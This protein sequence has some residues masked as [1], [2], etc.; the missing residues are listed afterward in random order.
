[1]AVHMHRP[2]R[3]GRSG[4]L[5]TPRVDD[6]RHD[7]R[8]AEFDPDLFFSTGSG[9]AA[10]NQ[11]EQAKAICFTC[12]VQRECLNYALAEGLDYGVFGGTSPD[13]RRKF[14]KAP[15]AQG[16]EPGQRRCED[17]N[18]WFTPAASGRHIYCPTCSARKTQQYKD[19]YQRSHT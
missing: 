17:C 7:A 12:P 11:D 14:R 15:A 3:V 1:M 6:W 16:G 13:D 4:V 2:S 9:W 10:R 19:D 5:D 18:G 8:C